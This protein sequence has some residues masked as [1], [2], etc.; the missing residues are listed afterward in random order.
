[1]D[2]GRDGGGVKSRDGAR[3]G[4]AEEDGSERRLRKEEFSDKEIG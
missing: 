3:H 1:M 2:G 4:K